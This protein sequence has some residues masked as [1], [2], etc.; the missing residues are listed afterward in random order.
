VRVKLIVRGKD[1][2]NGKI[3]DDIVMNLEIDK[4]LMDIEGVEKND[5]M[6]GR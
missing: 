6:D 5:N 3:I 4:K 1:I 2:E